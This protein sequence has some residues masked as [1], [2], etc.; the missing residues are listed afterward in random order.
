LQDFFLSR[1]YGLFRADRNKLRTVSDIG[2]GPSYFNVFALPA[3]KHT[4]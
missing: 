2:I 4:Q 3:V 1:N